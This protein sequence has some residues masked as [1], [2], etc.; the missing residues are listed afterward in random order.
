MDNMLRRLEITN[1]LTEF[2]MSELMAD[3]INN[4]TSKYGTLLEIVGIWDKNRKTHCNWRTKTQIW[5]NTWTNNRYEG[6]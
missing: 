1:G 2:K 6:G 5:T 3:K 4:I